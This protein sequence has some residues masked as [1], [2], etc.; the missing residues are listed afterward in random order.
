MKKDSQNKP[1]NEGLIKGMSKTTTTTTTPPPP[2]PPKPA[3][4]RER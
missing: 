2:P 4:H 1:V 3:T